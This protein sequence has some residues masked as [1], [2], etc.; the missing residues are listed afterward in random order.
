ML[1]ESSMKLCILAPDHA[2]KLKC[3]IYVQHLYKQIFKFE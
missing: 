2:R 1:I 3:S